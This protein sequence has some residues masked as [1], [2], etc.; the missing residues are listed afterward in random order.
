ML[1]PYIRPI[2]DPP[3]NAL[4]KKFGELGWT[5]DM[6]TFI[7]FLFGLGAIFAI[8]FH[9]YNLAATFIICNRL[10]DGLDGAIARQSHLTDFGGFLDI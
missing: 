5:A 6:M 9:Q 7:G 10:A 8:I 2:I 3:F 1:D 4:G